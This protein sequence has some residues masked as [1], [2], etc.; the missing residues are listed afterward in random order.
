MQRWVTRSELLTKYILFGFP[1]TYGLVDLLLMCQIKRDGPVGLLVVEAKC[2]RD[3]LRT[4]SFPVRI[5]VSDCVK[6]YETWQFEN[7]G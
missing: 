7:V 1:L 6:M 3:R 2:L 5:N 4:M